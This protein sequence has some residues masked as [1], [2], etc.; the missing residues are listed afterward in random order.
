MFRSSM[1]GALVLVALAGCQSTGASVQQ[2]AYGLNKQFEI[3]VNNTTYNMALDQSQSIV[4]SVEYISREQS[5]GVNNQKAKS[6]LRLQENSEQ[7]AQLLNSLYSNGAFIVR[8]YGETINSVSRDLYKVL[9]VQDGKVI[10]RGVFDAV[11]D[12]PNMDYPS[13]LWRN[14]SKLATKGLDTSKPFEI[15]VITGENIEKYHYQPNVKG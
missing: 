2:D 8:V 14:D 13:R 9:L 5:K 7:Q 3:D 6:I 10:Q 4:T 12:V 1:V 11:G 15:Q